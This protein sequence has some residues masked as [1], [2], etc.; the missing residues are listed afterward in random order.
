MLTDW[1]SAINPA[2]PLHFSRYFPHYKFDAPPT[3][4][5]TLLRAYDIAKT[6]LNYVYLGNAA[7]GN[8]SDTFCPGCGNLLVKRSHY[9]VSM[10]G[11]RNNA[12]SSCGIPVDFVGT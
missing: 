5:E 12:C 6:K 9:S 3:P 2:I 11:I 8:T 7:V 10:N 4:V 1:V